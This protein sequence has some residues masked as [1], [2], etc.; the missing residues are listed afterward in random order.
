MMKKMFPLLMTFLSG[1]MT[2]PEKVTPVQ[3]FQIDRYLGKWYEIARLDH[4]SERDLSNVTAEYLRKK[5]QGVQV[6]NRGYH[7]KKNQWKQI[8]G[9]AYF[10]S[11]PDIGFLK[12]SF[13]RPFYGAYI[14]FE[15]DEKNYQY[16]L[17]CGP[18]KNYLWLLARTP[19]LDDAVKS[20]LIAKAKALG[21]PTD[22]LVL[23]THS[24]R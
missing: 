9:R 1:C 23:P 6:I 19:T 18:S 21:F 20:T 17:V 24:H 8:I 3:N 10:A 5:D 4:R 22:S 2:T 13:F 16:A 12:V 11:A 7:E 15:L 14:V